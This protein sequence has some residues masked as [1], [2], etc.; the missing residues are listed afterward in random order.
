MTL[1]GLLIHVTRVY[2]RLYS[3]PWG[4]KGKYNSISL[5]RWHGRSTLQ[6]EVP[7]TAV[8]AMLKTSTG[9][10]LVWLGCLEHHPMDQKVMGLILGQGTYPG[11]G[12]NPLLACV[13]EGNQSIFLSHLDVSLSLKSNEK[14]NVLGEDLKKKDKHWEAQRCGS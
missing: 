13:R 12:F 14:K 5:S 2:R 9:P 11:C 3:R 10:W 6:V 4:Y 7:Q 1:G 8:A